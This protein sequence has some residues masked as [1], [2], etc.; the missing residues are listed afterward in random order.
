MSHAEP[1]P[2]KA[3]WLAVAREVFLS[4]ERWRLTYNLVMVA[5]V[6]TL[7]FVWGGKDSNWVR[8]TTECVLGGIVANLLYFA[9]PIADVYL[10]WLGVC[11]AV[12][13]RALFVTGVALSMGLATLTIGTILIQP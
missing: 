2:P 10:R 11:R 4:W 13:P 6:V 12:V 9:G 8:L 1:G 7:A 3:A 5:F